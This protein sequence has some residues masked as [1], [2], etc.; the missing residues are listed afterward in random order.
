VAGCRCRIDAGC[1]CRGAGCRIDAGCRCRVAGCWIDARCR[2]AGCG[3]T[4]SGCFWVQHRHPIRHPIRVFLCDIVKC[5]QKRKNGTSYDFRCF[6]T[7]T[8]TARGYHA[9]TH[10]FSCILHF[11]FRSHFMIMRNA[12]TPDPAPD[13]APGSVLG[14]ATPRTP[15]TPGAY[16]R[17]R[18]RMR[19]YAI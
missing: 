4:R 9:K 13:P 5:P 3:H 1:R 2:V 18:A 11:A 8:Y 7:Q 14:V 17:S 16:M 12:K 10:F 19:K 6:C 15:R